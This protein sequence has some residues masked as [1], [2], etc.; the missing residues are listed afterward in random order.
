M[1]ELVCDKRQRIHP[2]SSV[3]R[4]QRTDERKKEKRRSDAEVLAKCPTVTWKT[5]SE[6]RHLSSDSR[7]NCLF[8][9]GFMDWFLFPAVFLRL[10]VCKRS[11]N[12]FVN[13]MTNMLIW[14]LFS[15]TPVYHSFNHCKLSLCFCTLMKSTTWRCHMIFGDFSVLLIKQ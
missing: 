4:F 1:L 6:Q 14:G 13:E 8:W 10:S 11:L 7:H 15:Q 3:T 2:P 9:G 12:K 5:S